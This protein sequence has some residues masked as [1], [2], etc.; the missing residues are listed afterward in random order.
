MNYKFKALTV[1]S[2]SALLGA[3]AAPPRS[4]YS[5]DEMKSIKSIVVE[6]P[7]ATKYYA[8]SEGS[9]PLVVLPGIGIIAAAVTGAVSGGVSALANRKN[10]TFDDL[11]TEKLGKSDLN[12]KFVDQIEASLRAQGYEITEVDGTAPDMPKA[13]LQFGRVGKLEGSP[14]HGADAIMIVSI[15]TGYYAAGVFEPYVRSASV[16]VAI[17]KADTLKPV[18]RDR[19]SQ[20]AMHDSAYSYFHFGDL[21]A[22]LPHAIQGIDEATMG[23]V[24]EFNADMLASRGM[25]SPTAQTKD[26][27]TA[28]Q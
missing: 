24:P 9:T 20:Y 8:M 2:L 23:F 17:F 27:G 26:L 1:L 28:L 25:P 5:G 7:P 11:V 13:V 3:C 19:L 4:Q 22:D 16:N 10:P 12:R 18:F 15:A 21:T 14:Y 6:T